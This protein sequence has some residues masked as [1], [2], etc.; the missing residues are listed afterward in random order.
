M[1]SRSHLKYNIFHIIIEFFRNLVVIYL[2]KSSSTSRNRGGRDSPK[3]IASGLTTLEQSSQRGTTS[4]VTLSILSKNVLKMVNLYYV[5]LNEPV[6]HLRLYSFLHFG[7]MQWDVWTVP[8]ASTI[9][10]AGIPATCSKASLLESK[11]RMKK[12]QENIKLNILTHSEYSGEVRDPYH[13][14]I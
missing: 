2:G 4:D 7:F 11:F 5:N 3:K 13:A 12:L 10:S 8:W 6:I 14:T 9:L 1:M